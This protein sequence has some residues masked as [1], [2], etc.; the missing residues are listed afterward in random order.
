MSADEKDTLS[1][2]LEDGEQDLVEF[3]CKGRFD[4]ARERKAEWRKMGKESDDKY[5]H[6]RIG[7]FAELAFAKQTDVYPSQ[8]LSPKINTKVSGRDMGDTVYKGLRFDVKATI[9]DNGVLWIDKINQ[10]IDYYVFFVVTN[11]TDR[12]VCKLRG[13]IK[14]TVLHSKGARHRKQFK[15]PCIYA[16]QEELTPWWVFERSLEER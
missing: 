2:I 5:S 12:V 8:V 14:A 1:V 4:R 16:E 13:L 6:D 11:Q 9:H 15:F 10:N 3:L 7:L